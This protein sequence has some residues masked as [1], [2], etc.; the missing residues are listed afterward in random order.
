MHN[1]AG[2]VM[3]VSRI[4]GML[5][6]DDIRESIE[7]MWVLLRHLGEDMKSL[8]VVMEKECTLNCSRVKLW[9]A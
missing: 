2:K 5:C 1:A 6:C 9:R 7:F 8:T 3:D 4:H